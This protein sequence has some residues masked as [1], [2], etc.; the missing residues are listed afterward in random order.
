MNGHGENKNQTGKRGE[1]EVGARIERVEEHQKGDADPDV[2]E[3]DVEDES[4]ECGGLSDQTACFSD[5]ESGA[6]ARRGVGHPCHD[7]TSLPIVILT[8]V[9]RSSISC[10]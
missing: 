5:K 10:H 7:C 4:V 1:D 2:D 8:P 3:V 6:T 9:V